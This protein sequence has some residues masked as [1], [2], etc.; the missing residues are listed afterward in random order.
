MVTTSKVQELSIARRIRA[1]VRAIEGLEMKSIQHLEDKR[2]RT[3]G[4]VFFLLIAMSGVHAQTSDSTAQILDIQTLTQSDGKRALLTMPA[5]PGAWQVSGAKSTQMLLE[6]FESENSRKHSV[7]LEGK[8]YRAS[9][10]LKGT[11]SRIAFDP[12]RKRFVGL[13]PSIRVELNTNI[14]AAT[15]AEVVDAGRITTFRKLGFHIIELPE[16]VHPVDAVKTIQ[17]LA[18]EPNATVR[19]RAMKLEW[20]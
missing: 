14:D 13:L 10:P 15:L 19:T 20:R 16:D 9:T 6:I 1:F 5:R 12:L 18:C 3:I 17:R 11:R 2:A 8:I 7:K 4:L